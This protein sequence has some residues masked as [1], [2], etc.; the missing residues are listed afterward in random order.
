MA[1]SNR[2]DEISY[3]SISRRNSVAS[4]AITF[5]LLKTH[6]LRHLRERIR[7]GEI[8]ERSLARITGISQPHLHNVLKGKRSL[9]TAKADRILSCL[10]LDLRVFLDQAG[11]PGARP[12]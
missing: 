4:G 5:A 10:H 11:P 9:S 6:L 2:L 1:E 3:S 7:N 12:G 8:T